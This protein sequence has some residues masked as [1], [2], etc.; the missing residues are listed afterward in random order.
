MKEKLAAGQNQKP[1]INQ[2]ADLEANKKPNISVT[3][4]S[5]S[6]FLSYI[7]NVFILLS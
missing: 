4:D 7:V 3:K 5:M 1:K 6:I 2:P